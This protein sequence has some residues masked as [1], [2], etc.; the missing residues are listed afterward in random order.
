MYIHLQYCSYHLFGVVA[1]VNC[2]CC[3][4]C[5][6]PTVVRKA[7]FSS[8]SPPPFLAH[9]STAENACSSSAVVEPRS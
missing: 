5:Q 8:S 1:V 9:T 6:V 2:C 7:N 4:P 3:I